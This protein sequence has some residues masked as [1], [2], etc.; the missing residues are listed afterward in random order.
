MSNPNSQFK[1]FSAAVVQIE[2]VLTTMLDDQNNGPRNSEY[3]PFRASYEKYLVAKISESV[4]M[5][6]QKDLYNE[7]H[8]QNL[9]AFV[10]VGLLESAAPAQEDMPKDIQPDE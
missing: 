1:K 3:D 9:S 6:F 7:R 8:W 10:N 2:D 5:L 4:A